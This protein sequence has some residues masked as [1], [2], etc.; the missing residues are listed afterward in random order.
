MTN[1]F[2]SIP[3]GAEEL[4]KVIIGLKLKKSPK[5][6]SSGKSIKE[7]SGGKSTLQNEL[8]SD[9][10]K[11]LG[12]GVPERSEELPLK[13]V[14]ALV[15]AILPRAPRKHTNGLINRLFSS[16]MPAGFNTSQA[17][18][19]LQDELGLSS[20]ASDSVFLL[21][22]P[23]EPNSRLA[24]ESSAKKWLRDTTL[25][26]LKDKGIQLETASAASSGQGPV[27]S[28]AALAKIEAK[29]IGLMR[30]QMELLGNY[31]GQQGQKNLQHELAMVKQQLTS[32]QQL[33]DQWLL[34]HGAEYAEG[35]K[36]QFSP[37]KVRRYDSYWNWAKQDCLILY[38]DIIF[39]RLKNVDREVAI[40][41]R[42]VMNRADEKLLRYMEY[43]LHHSPEMQI[44]PGDSY[45]L[46]QRYGD[47]L[48]ENVRQALCGPPLYRDLTLLTRPV[49]IFKDDGQ[50]LYEE[51]RRE[52]SSS[53][54][55][56]VVEMSKGAKIDG[57]KRP[58][59]FMEDRQ[60]GTD[61]K[62]TEEYLST[63]AELA[64]N[65]LSLADKAVLITGCGSGSIGAEVL[66][67]LLSAGAKVVACTSSFSRA[68]ADQF[69]SYYEAHGARG[70][71]LVVCPLNQASSQDVEAIVD[72]I[73]G[74][75]GWDLDHVIPFG[76]ISENGR[77][78][79]NL[80]SRSELAHRLM[81]TNVMRLAGAILKQKRSR[82]IE[83]RPAQVMLPLSD[84]HGIFGGDGFYGES[85]AALETLLNRWYA[86]DWGQYLS[87]VGAVIG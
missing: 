14:S 3:I 59:I 33:L 31:I 36:A 57:V 78:L 38:Y 79:G 52:G 69:R 5:E 20:A 19:F 58:W 24:D 30:Q 77:D 82:H 40:K 72:W 11:E 45:K 16:K 41:C 46:A 35:I 64:N 49:T 50:V 23:M 66:K 34:E 18:Q 44:C 1:L 43:R 87:I 53:F 83:T 6:I 55:G 15:Q 9:L 60:G 32:G 67:G 70:S 8:L 7:L 80:D 22:L 75:L 28:A 84:N 81:L 25:S 76:A 61:D 74:T 10:Q 26:I 65:G 47:L 85:K 17:K 2:S 27:I 13:E 56:Y 29:Q 62:L 63:L 51:V 73:Y 48:I 86:E 12:D 37:L 4:L 71:A 39:G 68:T 54:E 42:H 21:S